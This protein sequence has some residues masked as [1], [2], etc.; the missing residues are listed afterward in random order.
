MDIGNK[1]QKLSA[2][3]QTPKPHNT[4]SFSPSEI[5]IEKA[6]KYKY[7]KIHKN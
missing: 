5:Y 6:Q 3:G 7:R 4:P 1:P 2:E